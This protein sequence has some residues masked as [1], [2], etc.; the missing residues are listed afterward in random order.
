MKV[1]DVK[2]YDGSGDNRV[3]NPGETREATIAAQAKADE[4][5]TKFQEWLF[6][7]AEKKTI[8]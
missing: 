4:M 6:A 8:L 1:I 5:Q 3:L 2:V 7:T